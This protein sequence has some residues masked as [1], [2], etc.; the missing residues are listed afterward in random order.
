MARGKGETV[1]YILRNPCEIAKSHLSL[2]TVKWITLGLALLSHAFHLHLKINENF[3]WRT[4]PELALFSHVVHAHM[5]VS[6][7]MQLRL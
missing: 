3:L 7:V 1:N 6:G 2:L 5:K 4:T